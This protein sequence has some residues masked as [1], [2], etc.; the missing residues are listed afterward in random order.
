MTAAL[1]LS[2]L[3]DLGVSVRAD[4]GV[5]RLR[6][7]SAVPPDLLAEVRAHKAEV[8]ALLAANDAAVVPPAA[9]PPATP[10]QAADEAADREAIAAEPLWPTAPRMAEPLPEQVAALAEAMTTLML[11]S[12]V[13]AGTT[14]EAALAYC[15]AQAARRLALLPD[16][17]ARGLLVAASRTPK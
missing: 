17:L 12:P 15:R 4:E 2:R 14:P 16:P 7:A 6:P 5:L 8:L 10:E 13:Y 3:G 9:L 11:A 1:L